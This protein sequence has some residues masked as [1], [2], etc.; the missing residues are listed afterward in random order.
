MAS[1]SVVDLINLGF[2]DT[3]EAHKTLGVDSDG[4]PWSDTNPIPINIESH[5]S[6]DL[7]GI[8]PLTVGTTAVELT[9]ADTTEAIII[10]S[11]INNTGNIYVGKS[12]VTI[13]SNYIIS[14]Y[15]GQ[16]VEMDYDDSS[17]SI[18]VVSDVASQTVNAGALK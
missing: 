4:N 1:D 6:T 14:L 5:T 8:S 10:Q 17:N 13:T 9:F 15:P 16:S 2:D 12:D 7:E 18:Y 3:A 11:D